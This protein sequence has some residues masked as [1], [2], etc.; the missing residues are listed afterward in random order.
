MKIPTRATHPRPYTLWYRPHIPKSY[1]IHFPGLCSLAYS[2]QVIQLSYP[3]A[4]IL[5]IHAWVIQVYTSPGDTPSLGHIRVHG[6]RP[7]TSTEAQVIGVTQVMYGNTPAGHTCSPGL[8]WSPGHA[9]YISPGL[10]ISQVMDKHIS[11]G[12]WTDTLSPGH[13]AHSNPRP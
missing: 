1:I 10:R 3:Q 11:P 13:D 12:Q 7:Y 2:A 5:A 4:P 9:R 8:A 6:P